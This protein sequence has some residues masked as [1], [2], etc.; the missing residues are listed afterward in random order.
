[1]KRW[2]YKL[3]I[4]FPPVADRQNHSST[5]ITLWPLVES[6]RTVSAFDA[7]CWK[8]V[9][10]KRCIITWP[11]IS[12]FIGLCRNSCRHCGIFRSI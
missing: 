2:S 8:M 7:Y 9:A 3:Y 10:S 11:A 4:F 1:M 6:I 12:T 5:C